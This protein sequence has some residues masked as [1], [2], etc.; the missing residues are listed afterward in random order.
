MS[1][2][3]QLYSSLL[4]K[5]TNQ[6][7]ALYGGQLAV[8]GLSLIWTNPTGHTLAPS[9]S[10]LYQLTQQHLENQDME[11][12]QLNF[13]EVILKEESYPHIPEVCSQATKISHRTQLLRISC[14]HR[15]RRG[16]VTA[17]QSNQTGEMIDSN[18]ITEDYTSEFPYIFNIVLLIIILFALSLLAIGWVMWFMDPGED[19]I[20][21][22]MTEPAKLKT[23]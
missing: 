12:F 15:F 5:L 16:I 1:A 10:D 20:I 23:E 21:Y 4:P 13:P 2:A 6:I 22:R 14:P 7:A 17:F 18:S 9:V 11:H 8:F 3:I 19:S